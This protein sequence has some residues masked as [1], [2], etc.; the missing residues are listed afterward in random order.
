LKPEFDCF[1]LSP[2]LRHKL[3]LALAF[4]VLG[5]V[6]CTSGFALLVADDDP[7]PRSA[8]ALAPLPSSSRETAPPAAA[9][10]MPAVDTVL[11]QKIT[12]ADVIKSCQR[13]A[14]DGVDPNCDSGAAR[15]P[16][17]VQAVTDEP[18]TAELPI[19][20][21]NG[22]AV[23]APESAVLVASTPPLKAGAPESTDVAPPA[24]AEAPAPEGPATK[25][26]KTARHQGSR[27]D[28]DSSLWPF[29]H[30]FRRHGYAQ[31]RPWSLFR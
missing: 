22:A 3:S 25:P 21:S 16:G 7:D 27:R 4:T 11:A 20:H 19:G 15:K 26:R 24:L 14:S 23:A 6:A 31:Q 17:V 5:L 12:K 10:E 29:D 9:A 8:F 13:N 30:L 2:T 1:F 28:S 18:G